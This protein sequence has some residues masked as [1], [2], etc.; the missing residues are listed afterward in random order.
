MDPMV[1]GCFGVSPFQKPS[2][3]YDTAST[4]G[5]Q[6][7]WSHDRHTS[8]VGWFNVSMHKIDREIKK[9]TY[10]WK[11]WKTDENRSLFMLPFSEVQTK[12]EQTF[13]VPALCSL[14][15]S[16]ARPSLFQQ[17]QSLSPCRNFRKPWSI[18]E[19]FFWD[20]FI[21]FRIKDLLE[22]NCRKKSKKPA[23]ACPF[24]L[25]PTAQPK[26]NRQSFPQLGGHAAILT[27]SQSGQ[28]FLWPAWR[29]PFVGSLWFA[30]KTS[31]CFV[32]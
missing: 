28:R 10:R 17:W 12:I 26:E 15:P 6:R 9:S 27:G 29:D 8:F 23:H 20:C 13:V 24:C 19:V 16:T 30:K 22:I 18:F 21:L 11:R 2:F 5:L 14:L 3:A 1:L 25:M 31:L 4:K 7:W 32:L